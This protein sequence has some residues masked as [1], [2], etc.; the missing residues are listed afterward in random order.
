VK[1][2][3]AAR[4]WTI[5]LASRLLVL[6]VGVVTVLLL[7]PRDS[8]VP[9]RVSADPVLNLPARW[10]AGWYLGIARTGY[11][12]RPELHEHRHALAFFPAYPVGM[13]IAGELV[14]VPA[15]VFNAP[16]LLDNGN[17]RVLWGGVLLS[18]VCFG[19][20]ACYAFQVTLLQDGDEGAAFR[21]IVLLA[22]YPFALFFS[23]PYSESLF[24]MVSAGTV[25]AWLRD[26][27]GSALVW[28]LLTG[29]ARSNGWTLTFA[30]TADAIIR[31]RARGVS[32][33]VVALGPAIGA[34]SYCV[35]VYTI[36]GNPFEW[37][38]AQEGWGAALS[39]LSFLTR[40]VAGI[41]HQ[42]FAGYVTANPIDVLT[43][44]ATAIAVATA[45]W[46]AYRREW[47]FAVWTIAYLAPAL[48]VDLP[49]TGRMT[50]VLVPVFIQLARAL[51][52][53]AFAAA[54]VLFGAGQL[55]LAVRFFS[56]QPPY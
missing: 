42:G 9:F 1:R 20:G 31:R 3:L 2:G 25:L 7:F 44:L 35:Y 39:P 50:A 47:L 29:L 11:D 13:R 53:P 48:A 38:T 12:W 56:W 55:A 14:T 32:W 16:R 54:L 8:P 51:K 6:A 24:L 43:F 33:M 21:T 27:P 30:L 37:A 23:A 36:T 10:D 17:T 52:G 40:R 5:A 28:G 34:L 26:R 4:V 49:A 15:R 18:L 45:V 41:A 19:V 22:A 46:Q